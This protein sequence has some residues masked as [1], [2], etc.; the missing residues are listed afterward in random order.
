MLFLLGYHIL[1]LIS[2]FVY[3]DDLVQIGKGASNNTLIIRTMNI[4]LSLLVVWDVEHSSIADY[5]PI[6]VQH[7]IYPELR[8]IVIGDVICLTS[9]LVNQKGKKPLTNN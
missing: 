4:G 9:S 7:A 3:R 1:L 2:Y 5:V 8:D 6:P